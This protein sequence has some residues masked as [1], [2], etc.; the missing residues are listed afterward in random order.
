MTEVSG[1]QEAHIGQE[2]EAHGAGALEVEQ[3]HGGSGQQDQQREA[4]GEADGHGDGGGRTVANEAQ[5][6]LRGRSGGA[7]G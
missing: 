1:G 4:G 2:R 5:D 7:V 6:R 3:L